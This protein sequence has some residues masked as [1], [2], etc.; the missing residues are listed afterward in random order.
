MNLAASCSRVLL[1][2]YFCTGNVRFVFC[3]RRTNAWRVSSEDMRLTIQSFISNAISCA[4]IKIVALLLKNYP[5]RFRF[6]S[7]RSL[8]FLMLDM[9][10]LSGIMRTILKPVRIYTLPR[11]TPGIIS[12]LPFSLL[13]Y[14][15]RDTLFKPRFLDFYM[16]FRLSFHSARPVWCSISKSLMS[17]RK[18]VDHTLLFSAKK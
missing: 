15:Y 17:G 7:R 1:D 12:I 4:R 13:S 10:E 8:K 18:K 6:S 2:F 16:S 5:T 14:F 9:K 11:A 3:K